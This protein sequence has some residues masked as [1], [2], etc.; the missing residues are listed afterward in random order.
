[1]AVD[2]SSVGFSCMYR[3]LFVAIVMSCYLHA[4]N[5]FFGFFGSAWL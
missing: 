4:K 1:V 2:F 5:A 3:F